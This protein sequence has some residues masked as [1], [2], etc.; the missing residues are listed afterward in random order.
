MHIK[1]ETIS[2]VK[3][4]LTILSE[5]SN[6]RLFITPLREEGEEKYPESNQQKSSGSP[7]LEEMQNSGSRGGNKEDP[8]SGLKDDQW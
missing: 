6:H 4:D 8:S 5:D 2:G 3:K 1:G 7:D